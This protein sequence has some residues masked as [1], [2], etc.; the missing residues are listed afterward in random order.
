MWRKSKIILLSFSLKT[1]RDVCV[2]IDGLNIQEVIYHCQDSIQFCYRLPNST[3]CKFPHLPVTSSFFL[4]NIL[5]FTLLTNSRFMF[6]CTHDMITM[7]TNK[8][9]V[10]LPS[11]AKQKRATCIYNTSRHC[12]QLSKKSIRGNFWD[13]TVLN[14]R[15]DLNSTTKPN[16]L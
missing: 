10:L 2:K 6:F 4:L 12:K 11:L 5:T 16:T 14:V 7:Y 8:N 15:T 13:S 3:I 1:Q 9:T